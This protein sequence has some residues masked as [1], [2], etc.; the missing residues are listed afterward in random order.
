VPLIVIPDS[1]IFPFIVPKIVWF[2]SFV[3]LMLGAYIL[4]LA[5]NWARYRIRLTPI[6]TVVGLFFISFAISTF[7]GVD[8]YHSLWDN[9]ERMLGLF[10]IFHYVVYYF[11]ATSVVREWEDWKWLLRAFLF[12]G[13]I[14][15]FI[16]F[17]QTYV[18]HD[19]VVNQGKVSRVSST[20][21]NAI[22]FSG[23]GLFLL[24]VG[25]LLAIKE[26][27]KKTNLWFWYAVVGGLLGF[28][29]IFGGGTR[30]AFLGLVAGLG[31]LAVSYIISLREHKKIRQGLGILI[32]LGVIVLAL[33]FNFRQ[34]D[35]VKNIPAVGRLVNTQISGGTANTRIMAWGIAVDAWKERPVFGWGPNNYYYAF[36]KYY[37]AEFLEHGWGETWFDNA[38]S[39]VMNTLAVQGGVGIVTY[40]GVFVVA[41]IM[42]WRS[43][44]KDNLDPHIVAV[45]SAF[46][47][48]HLVSLVTVFDNPTSYLYFFFF[49]ALISRHTNNL[50]VR[51]EKKTSKNIS[52]GLTTIV[53]LVVLLMVFST[54]INPARAN[55]AA[56]NVIRVLNTGQ[57][58][59]EVYN[60]ATSTPSPHIDDIR[61]DVARISGNIIPKLS[62][63]N[64]GLEAF[65][66]FELMHSELQ[67]NL[68]LHPMDIRINI[69]LA[70]INT[71]GAQLEQ[72]PDLLFEA[73]Q[74]LEDALVL[75]PKR[76]QLQYTLASLKSQLNKN[77]EAV[78]ILQDSIDNDPR[79]G[80]GWWRMALLYK[81]MGDVEKAKEILQE[82]MDDGIVFDAKG[83][84]VVDSILQSE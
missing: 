35:F 83:S 13:G 39:V 33:L 48:A 60:H 66:L 24:F 26:K 47:I 69:E 16:G 18:N 72:S 38:H 76:Q 23:Y 8:W 43:R 74:Y 29:G 59:S 52:V 63:N 55:I 70:F 5:S 14:V 32:I 84:G 40:L 20:L 50:D 7:A 19:L 41:F 79:I 71:L 37:R 77:D 28:W 62:Q 82:A 31:V 2:R 67:K 34:T 22:Y 45:G 30:G 3:M 6:N 1:Y 42:L 12:A 36:N 44:K 4:L 46:L 25:Y 75:S 15:M 73:E 27:I 57:D 80:E 65:R 61:K 9:H 53:S 51:A 54:N 49:L 10:T 81:Q 56:L 64:K 17:L 11:I 21:G 78:K 58:I 68:E